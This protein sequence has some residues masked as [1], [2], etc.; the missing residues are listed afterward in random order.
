[1]ASATK[2][3]K[4][5]F[6]SRAEAECAN[7]VLQQ[8]LTL[9]RIALDALLRN[10]F[11]WTRSFRAA[12]PSGESVFSMGIARASAAHGG[13]VIVREQYGNQAPSQNAFWADGWIRG[14]A[15]EFARF[16]PVD[17]EARAYRDCFYALRELYH[18]L[19]RE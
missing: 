12:G 4:Y 2:R 13:L 5:V 8:E 16:T 18:H 14:R 3:R 17:A 6:K 10:E 15:E 19:T 9:H 11:T 1:M 7:T